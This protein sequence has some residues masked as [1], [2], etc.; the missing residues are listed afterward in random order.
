MTE[1]PWKRKPALSDRDIERA[2]LAQEQSDEEADVRR[3]I[4]EHQAGQ[5]ELWLERERLF[6]A[7][8][9]VRRRRAVLG[10]V[11]CKQQRHMAQIKAGHIH[12][13]LTSQMEL[14]AEIRT[15]Q[16]RLR[17]LIDED[18]ELLDALETTN[19]RGDL[20][21]HRDLDDIPPQP[22]R[23]DRVEAQR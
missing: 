10:E 21:W 9:D 8:S 16:Q 19:A 2:V 3:A 6:E 17:A 11:L 7:R 13:T 12:A 15:T 1:N 23:T 4:E 22:V 20:P 5:H 14:H 18:A